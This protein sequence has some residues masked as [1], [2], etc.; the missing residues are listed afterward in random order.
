MMLKLRVKQN[1][2]LLGSKTFLVSRSK[3]IETEPNRLVSG[4][5]KKSG[6]I[7]LTTTLI[8]GELFHL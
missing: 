4:F 2:T 3:Q 5:T 1:I 7:L 8:K 6:K